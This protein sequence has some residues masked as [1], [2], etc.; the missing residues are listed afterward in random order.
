M[1]PAFR[2]HFG[3]ANPLSLVSSLYSTAEFRSNATPS[4]TLNLQDVTGGSSPSLI[5]PLLQPAVILDGAAHTE[6]APYGVPSPYTGW[7]VSLGI[8]AVVFFLGY[9]VG[10]IPSRPRS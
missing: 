5:G 8:F 10:S 3:D 1:V 4:I 6:V 7:F 2:Q 9:A